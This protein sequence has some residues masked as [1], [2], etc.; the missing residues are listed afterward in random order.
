VKV[1]RC[2]GTT[3]LELLPVGVWFLT[4]DILL[5]SREFRYEGEVSSVAHATI[6]AS[7][8]AACHH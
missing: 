6:K 3:S 2:S 4:P 7:T 8:S 5:S 1:E